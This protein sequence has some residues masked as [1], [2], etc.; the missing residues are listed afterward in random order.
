[1][2]NSV[3]YIS[4]RLTGGVGSNRDHGGQVTVYLR[5]PAEV[6]ASPR[7]GEETQECVQFHVSRMLVYGGAPSDHYGDPR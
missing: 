1:M 5:R 4:P 3:V 2:G 7:S 6:N